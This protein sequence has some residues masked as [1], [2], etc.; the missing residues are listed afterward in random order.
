MRKRML[1]LAATV[2]AFGVWAA[3]GAQAASAPGAAKVGLVG[4]EATFF[5]STGDPYFPEPAYLW[6]AE[7]GPG[8]VIFNQDIGANTV[9]V[10]VQL[11]NARPDR[12][13]AVNFVQAGPSGCGVD[14][15]FITT[16]SQGNGHVRIVEPLDPSA[17]AL[18]VSLAGVFRTES[19]VIMPLAGPYYRAESK[20]VLLR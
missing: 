3:V 14:D 20:Y 16:N 4:P 12:L 19:G 7:P 11:K 1:L 8:F 5:C 15:A 17:T 18:Q 2:A 10:N 6:P 13:F 9:S